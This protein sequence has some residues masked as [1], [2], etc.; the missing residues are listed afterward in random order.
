MI[1]TRSAIQNR[2]ARRPAPTRGTCLAAIAIVMV[3]MLSGCQTVSQDLSEFVAIFSV[4]TPGEA[5]RDLFDA[6]DPDKQRQALVLLAQ[7]PFGGEEPYVRA[8]RDLATNAVDPTVRITAIR[9]LARHGE[10]EDAT[11][12]AIANLRLPQR[13]PNEHVRWAAIEALQRLHNPGIVG[14]LITVLGDRS[15]RVETRA[16]AAVALGQYRNDSAFQ[17]LISALDAR[18]LSINIAARDSLRLM[19]GREFGFDS[20][21]WLAWYGQTADPFSDAQPYRYPTYSRRLGLL[22]RIGLWPAPTWEQP[23]P[24]I[25][26]APE[27]RRETYE[28]ADAA[29]N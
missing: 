24:P 7:A 10:P 8:Y 20:R 3:A 26:L 27:S 12:L 21:D 23:G 19:T 6:S 5:A 29:D 11:I 13:H 9:A 28:P 22:E 18:H 17:A 4:P 14:D 1:Y 25:G 16:G 2:A 15:E